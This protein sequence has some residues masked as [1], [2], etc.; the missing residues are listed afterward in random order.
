MNTD[1]YD[2]ENEEIKL[3]SVEISVNLRPNQCNVI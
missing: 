2:L 1:C 3:L